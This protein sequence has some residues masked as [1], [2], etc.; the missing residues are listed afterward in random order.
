MA[1]VFLGG[2]DG[3]R[4]RAWWPNLFCGVVVFM[5]ERLESDV[6]RSFEVSAP[7]RKLG[8]RQRSCEG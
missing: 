8:S 7:N 6:I 1:F 3:I 5:T 2:A 4:F